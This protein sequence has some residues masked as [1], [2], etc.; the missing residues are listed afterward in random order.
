MATP[1]APFLNALP[2][3]SVIITDRSLLYFF[4]RAS[5]IFSADLSGLLGIGVAKPSFALDSSIPALAHTKPCLVSLII[6][7]GPRAIIS[8][9]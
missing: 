7:S 3:V 4:S 6:K 2:W 8:L 5:L 1:T 9:E